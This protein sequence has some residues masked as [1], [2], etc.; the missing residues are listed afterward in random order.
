MSGS[1]VYDEAVGTPI[2]AGDETLRP[3]PPSYRMR[4]GFPVLRASAS[5]QPVTV[6]HVDEMAAESEDGTQAAGLIS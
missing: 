5:A 6:E 4:N 3:D 2:D 1:C